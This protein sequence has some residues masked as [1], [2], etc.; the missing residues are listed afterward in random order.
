MSTTPYKNRA[1]LA[2]TD[3]I[4]RN[5]GKA[6]A[7][8]SG[9]VLVFEMD[10]SL[11]TSGALARLSSYLRVSG[12]STAYVIAWGYD[13]LGNYKPGYHSAVQLAVTV[14]SQTDLNS[15]PL[16]SNVA[17]TDVWYFAI[18]LGP[19]NKQLL[20]VVLETL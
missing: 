12:M 11:V 14:G 10:G 4:C 2:I 8:L 5:D 9:S 3:Y 1:Q 7:L 16:P 17:T 15:I 20:K 6:C 19:F 18:N 13:N